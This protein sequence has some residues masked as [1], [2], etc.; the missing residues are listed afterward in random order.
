VAKI[1]T[2]TDAFPG[3]TLNSSNW[4]VELISDNPSLNGQPSGT[5]A[6]SGGTLSLHGGIDVD[7]NYYTSVNSQ[8][9]FDLTSSA[10]FVR[11]I[12]NTGS[13]DYDTGWGLGDSGL[14]NGYTFGVTGGNLYVESWS[15]G[16]SATVH[17]VTYNA[18]SH[19][20]LK[21]ACS[22]NTLTFYAS[23]D[24]VTWGSALYSTTSVPGTGWSLTSA[25]VQIFYGSSS[26]SASPSGTGQ[27]QDFNVLPVI[28][29]A[30]PLSGTGSLSA[31]GSGGTLVSAFAALT[32]G[33][34]RGLLLEGGGAILLEG[35]VPLL[36]EGGLAGATLT[37]SATAGPPGNPVAFLSAVP[38][39][40]ASASAFTPGNALAAAPVLTASATAAHP[41][42]H[43]AAAPVLLA[44]P[45]VIVTESAHLSASPSLSAAGRV[46]MLLARPVLAAAALVTHPGAVAL[47]APGSLAAATSQSA[48][49]LA[50]APVLLAPGR[51]A[52]ARLLAGTAL[53]ASGQY[54]MPGQAALYGGA[55]L[56]AAALNS[57]RALAALRASTSL[58]AAALDKAAASAALSAAPH[59]A[60]GTSASA[61]HLAAAPVLAAAG[62]HSAVAAAHLSAPGSS[63]AA[64]RVTER[65]SAGLH[66]SAAL[67]AGGVPSRAAR[68]HLSAAA[69]L[70]AAGA[71][72]KDVPAA[73]VL[74]AAAALRAAGLRGTFGTAALASA[75]HLSARGTRSAVARA[76]LA[77]SPQVTSSGQDLPGARLS[78]AASL[79]GQAVLSRTG[80]ALLSG[81]ARLTGTAHGTTFPKAAFR[82]LGSFTPVPG[83]VVQG[84]S[85]FAVSPSLAASALTRPKLPF[86]LRPK[87]QQPAWQRDVQR[88]AVAQE[89]QRHAQALWQYGE[90][91]VFALMWRPQ[92][93]GLGLARRCT[94]CY[95]P[96]QVIT[97]LPPETPPPL[98]WA[99]ASTEAQ[100]SAA[101]GQG[102]QFRCTLC[103]GTQVIAAGAARVPG[104][105][106]LIVRPAI[107]T[108]TDQ[109]QQ[110][111]AKG[112][113]NTGQ[114]A[115]QST[116]DFRVNTLD[117][118]FRADG[119]RYQ[120]AVPARTTLRTG[121]GSPWQASANISYNLA[122]AALED[123]RASVAYVI[124]PAAAQ[125]EQVLGTYTRVPADYAWFEQLNGPLV[126]GEEPSPSAS[127]LVQPSESLG[128]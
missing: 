104:V 4:Y 96:A 89:R 35:G 41:G 10:A 8:A 80:R 18:T 78:A 83:G 75:A 57:T 24:G 88:F 121:F 38:S 40:H 108:D 97:D 12:P 118:F 53:S 44:A 7:A 64:A 127:G 46:P 42:S 37:A 5:I 94:R 32:A 119:R 9:A 6:V 31:S 115:V 49:H 126:P 56:H 76:A 62:G 51:A 50:A 63:G 82:A 71:A 33:A 103:F 29:G 43:L 22:T 3:T 17:T 110:R 77:A 2:L 30:A 120:L 87:G 99:T 58:A 84:A 98:G 106:A 23:S 20:W 125:V 117:Y 19:K 95:V 16:S 47:H 66:G 26:G 101:Y 109:N 90:L 116:P 107:L 14:D 72:H 55:Q 70:S 21:I 91:V 112:V 113:V 1:G 48:A 15:G 39:L 79:S 124:P 27:F 68:G 13:S 65:A 28:S 34:E 74:T 52:A 128:V 81:G 73:A 36:Q 25:Y 60:A 111:S 61:A 122:S 114:V 93:I 67:S 102:N 92:D 100:I 54:F 11:V 85:S 45:R 86:P 59:L 123:P 105:R 69:A